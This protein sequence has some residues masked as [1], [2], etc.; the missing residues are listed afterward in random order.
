MSR[1]HQPT[2]DLDEYIV[3]DTSRSAKK[4][5]RPNADGSDEPACD[6]PLHGGDW[7]RKVARQTIFYDECVNPQ[8]F[9]GDTE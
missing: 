1:A 8:C 2:R 3:S 5:H 9:G 6:A 7:T 4:K